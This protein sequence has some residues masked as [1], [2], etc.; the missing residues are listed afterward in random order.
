MGKM[1]RPYLGQEDVAPLMRQFDLLLKARFPKREIKAL[2]IPHG[3]DL[4]TGRLRV[5][6]EVDGELDQGIFFDLMPP[7]DEAAFAA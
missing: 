5:A 1:A 7:R 3:P 6:I 2:P 4:M